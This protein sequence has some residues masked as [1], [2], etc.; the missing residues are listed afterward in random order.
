[1]LDV[2]KMV[3]KAGRA[4]RDPPFSYPATLFSTF[5]EKKLGRFLLL[6]I[7]ERNIAAFLVYILRTQKE[8]RGFI[9][10]GN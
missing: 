2:T 6:T 3:Q 9:E 1:M 4:P 8:K 10:S 5:L 7:N